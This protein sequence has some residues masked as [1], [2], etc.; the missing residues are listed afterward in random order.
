MWTQ[1]AEPVIQVQKLC[2]YK[3]GGKTHCT[4]ALKAEACLSGQNNYRG[5]VKVN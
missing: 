3:R 4:K 5:E 2:Q 1:R